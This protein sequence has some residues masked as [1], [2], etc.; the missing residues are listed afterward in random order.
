MSF[1][2]SDVVVK[3]SEWGKEAQEFQDQGNSN[4]NFEKDEAIF[5]S[6]VNDSREWHFH[7]FL[8]SFGSIFSIFLTIDFSIDGRTRYP[9]FFFHQKLPKNWEKFK[10]VGSIDLWILLRR[11]ITLVDW[12]YPSH[13]WGMEQSVPS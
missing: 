4:P 13:G 3:A 1:G 2:S 7:F 8:E 11:I 5:N 10:F 9:A 6:N 12:W